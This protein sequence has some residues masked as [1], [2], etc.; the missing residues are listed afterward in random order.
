MGSFKQYISEA[1]LSEKGGV[2]ANADLIYQKILDVLDHAHIDFGEDKIEFHIGRIIKNSD[3]D[4][5]MVIRAGEFDNVRL[6]KNKQNDEYTIV[7]DVTSKLP[8]RDQIDS[9]LAKDRTRALD[10]KGAIVKY[11]TDRYLENGS[12]SVKTK[13]E[14]DSNYNMEFENNY[15]GIVSKLKDTME[16][17][18][19]T[20]SELKKEMETADTG[21]RETVKRAMK[22]VIKDAFG[23][24]FNEFKKIVN[25]MMKDSGDLS[26]E[27]KE[28]L[29][30]RL[31]SFYDQ[32]IKPLLQK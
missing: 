27:N 26:K 22:S 19:G 29:A 11:L 7:V 16:E 28:K 30:N 15:E 31:E 3:I 8:L 12:N 23:D 32:R 24:N 20:I 2:E 1:I 17:V 10:I 25:G 5:S 13:Y 9:F 6:G 14:E 21:K 4:I 18:Q